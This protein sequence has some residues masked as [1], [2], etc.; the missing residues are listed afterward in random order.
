MRKP[1]NLLNALGVKSVKTFAHGEIS[2]ARAIQACALVAVLS[3]TI[4][5]Q[6]K[7][8][9]SHLSTALASQAKITHYDESAG[10]I[11]DMSLVIDGST[12]EA[13]YINRNAF[14]LDDEFRAALES[15]ISSVIAQ[16]EVAGSWDLY[17][18]A[19]LTT[20]YLSEDAFERQVANAVLQF[21]EDHNG[22]APAELPKAAYYTRANALEIES[23][24][25]IFIMAD[26]MNEALITS[27]K[28]RINR[29][30][31][32]QALSEISDEPDAFLM[33]FNIANRRDNNPL[34]SYNILPLVEAAVQVESTRLSL[35]SMSGQMFGI[36]EVAEEPA[37]AAL[38]LSRRLGIPVAVRT[39]SGSFADHYDASLKEPTEKT[40]NSAI[41]TG[42]D[43]KKGLSMEG[44]GVVMTEIPM[45]NRHHIAI[46]QIEM[47]VFEAN[48]ARDDRL[49]SADTAMTDSEFRA[50][51]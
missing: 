36:A 27:G 21:V 19:R 1:K 10:R 48:P 29:A 8:N 5:H 12:G 47:D 42:F 44:R 24:R 9:E 40:L 50:S 34:N 39:H 16:A 35:A 30:A 45:I 17:I 43:L 51:M 4:T 31:A 32:E 22:H 20:M 38:L 25:Q 15:E 11:A 49:F 18:G 23:A 6:G 3:V 28:S 33:S 2:I 14:R 46:P 37:M 13:G 26:A 7:V 41:K